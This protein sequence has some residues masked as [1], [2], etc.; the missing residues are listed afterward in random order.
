MQVRQ[1]PSW[2]PETGNIVR[3]VVKKAFGTLVFIGQGT[4]YKSQG[5]VTIVRDESETARGILCA[6]LV[7]IV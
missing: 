6:V 5:N 7:S 3:Q 2:L 4:E 1:C